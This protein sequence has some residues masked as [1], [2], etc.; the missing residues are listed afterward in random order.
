M[1]I[2]R[3]IRDIFTASISDLLATAEDPEAAVNQMIREIEQS[4]MVLR[5]ETAAAMASRKALGRRVE[6]ARADR[7]EWQAAAE[8]AVRQGDDDLARKA[9]TKKLAVQQLLDG[10]DEQVEAAEQ[11]VERLHDELH[12]VEDKVQEARAKRDT[13]VTK[14][15]LAGRRRKVA[16]DGLR[17][18]RDAGS[19][20]YS[21]EVIEGFDRLEQEVECEV[22]E[23]EALEQI[24]DDSRNASVRERF[25]EARRERD[26]EAQLRKLKE[27]LDD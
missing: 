7:E 23:A 22:A 14:R 26:V 8:A 2:F 24:Q 16:E 27:R 4:I 21:Y 20:G 5:R 17:S 3:R 1:T 6:K 25:G 13:L 19:A 18:G 12:R 10:L 15:R 11:A 9:L